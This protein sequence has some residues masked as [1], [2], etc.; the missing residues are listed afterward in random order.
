MSD[1]SSGGTHRKRRRKNTFPLVEPVLLGV[2]ERF[3]EMERGGVQRGKKGKG[4]LAAFRVIEIS[5][6]STVR[7]P[8]ALFGNRSLACPRPS[9]LENPHQVSLSPPGQML[10]T[11][12]G[13]SA[14]GFAARVG[15]LAIQKRPLFASEPSVVNAFRAMGGTDLE[16]SIR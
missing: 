3:E 4:G 9:S 2:R 11:I 13:F 10:S 16:V 6:P 8:L 1:R 7:R 14:F 12:L 15:Q 5:F